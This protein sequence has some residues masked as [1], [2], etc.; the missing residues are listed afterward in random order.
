MRL[1][2]MRSGSAV[3]HSEDDP[4]DL[5]KYRTPLLNLKPMCVHIPS[6]AVPSC[7]VYAL[8]VSWYRRMLARM[9]GDRALSH[10]EQDY[11]HLPKYRA[12]N[13]LLYLMPSL[14]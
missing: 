10:S 5:P 12:P 2:G 4:L 11:L 6:A 3:S 1:T 13:T 8:T 9:R 7:E 14:S